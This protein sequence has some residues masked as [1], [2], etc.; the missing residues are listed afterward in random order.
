MGAAVILYLKNVRKNKR[1]GSKSLSKIAIW[2]KMTR[3]ERH[4][5]DFKDKKISMKRKKILLNQIR[6]EYSRL[7]DQTHKEN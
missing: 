2:M 7:S 6:K 3:E 4:A 5:L 1:K